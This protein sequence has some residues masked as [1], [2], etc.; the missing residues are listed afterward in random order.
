MPPLTGCRDLA[1][2]SIFSRIVTMGAAI[3]L[4]SGSFS[5]TRANTTSAAA[6]KASRV[7][8]DG[9]NRGAGLRGSRRSHIRPQTGLLAGVHP[10]SDLFDAFVELELLDQRFCIVRFARFLTRWSRQQG[11]R[12]NLQQACGDDQKSRNIIGLGLLQARMWTRY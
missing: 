12:F 8:A 2:S 5:G 3:T 11:L 4:A 9:S 10:L 7:T 1:M 6:T